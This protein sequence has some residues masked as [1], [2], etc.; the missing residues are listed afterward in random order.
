M[1]NPVVVAAFNK[2]KTDARCCNRI[3]FELAPLDIPLGGVLPVDGLKSSGKLKD[4]NI[5]L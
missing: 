3:M 5:L 1:K 2:L 4:K